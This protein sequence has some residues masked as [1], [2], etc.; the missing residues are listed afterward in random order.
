MLL[1]T[2]ASRD[3]L[4]G[5]M[6][7]TIVPLTVHQ[8]A[9]APLPRDIAHRIAPRR[10]PLSDTRANLFTYRLDRDD[11]LISGGMALVPI[12]ARRR[13]AAAIASRLK[14]ELTLP[15]VPKVDYAWR[16]TAAITPDFLPRLYEFGPGFFGGIGCNGRGIAMTAM[17][18]EMLADAA[19]GVALDTLAV[20]V[21]EPKALPFHRLAGIAATAGL[22]R[23]RLRDWRAGVS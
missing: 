16:G 5:R 15:F 22:A 13:M 10:Q 7:Q 8:I 6:A 14:R 19:S 21:A 12:D 17:L 2:N 4:A 11:R 1:C 23:A 3:G 18:G 9:T 20:P